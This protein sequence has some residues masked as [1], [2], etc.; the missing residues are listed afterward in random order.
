MSAKL[1]ALCKHL[2]DTQQCRI[3]QLESFVDRCTLTQDPS[4]CG[5]YSELCQVRSDCTLQIDDFN[6]GA[7]T[8]LAQ[9]SAWLQDQD[10]TDQRDRLKLPDPELDITLLNKSGKS[11]IDLTVSFIDPLLLRED[12]TGNISWQGQQW[13]VI[14][15]PDISTA[16]TEQGVQPQENQEAAP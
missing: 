6:G 5:H 16:D 15:E 9:I 12:P 7:I 3:E 10:D 2:V 14:S 13:S 8:L 4:M 11:D 1:Q